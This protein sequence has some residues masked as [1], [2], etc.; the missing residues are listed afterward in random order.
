MNKKI[1]ETEVL[2]SYL[3]RTTVLQ[4]V[5]DY[6]EAKTGQ[7]EDIDRLPVTFLLSLDE[8]DKEVK[9]MYGA[10]LINNALRN[11]AKD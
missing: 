2:K 9:R 7:E 5:L 6:I 1:T 10:R 4:L 8:L 11:E 3:Q